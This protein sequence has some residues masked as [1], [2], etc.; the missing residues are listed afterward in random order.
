MHCAARTI[1]AAEEE[2]VAPIDAPLPLDAS[3]ETIIAENRYGYLTITPNATATGTTRVNT[4][5][6]AN[7]GKFDLS[8][9]KL[10]VAEDRVVGDMP[11]TRVAEDSDANLKTS[12]KSLVAAHD[13][14]PGE[15][16]SGRTSSPRA[17]RS[18]V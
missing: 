1:D 18:T 5:T 3:R 4:L 14:S 8:D 11:P 17:R 13:I 7:G 9:N 12:F 15:T 6:I 16:W 10:I 2:L